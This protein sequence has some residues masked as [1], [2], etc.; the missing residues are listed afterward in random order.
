MLGRFKVRHKIWGM[1]ALFI[2][3]MTLL[4]A[5]G[6]YST[7]DV[8]L[9]EKKI[10]TRH[11]VETA[12]SLLTYFHLQ[13][14]EG[15][16]SLS[17]AQQ[18]AL[19]AIND[20]RYDSTEYFWVNDLTLPVPKMVMH[21]TL[22]ELNDNILDA[23]QFNCATSMQ[24]GSDGEIIKTDGKKNLF[25]AFNEVARKSGAGYVTYQWPKPLLQGGVTDERYP[26]LS[27]IK[28]FN[29]WGWV[30]GS[31][32]YI[33][34]VDQLLQELFLNDLSIILGIAASLIFLGGVL[35]SSIS[36]RLVH[37]ARA[38]NAM[39]QGKTPLAPL[40]VGKND[41][42][43][44]LISGFNQMQNALLAKEDSLRLSASVFENINEGIVITDPSDRILSINPSFTRLTGY[45][46]KDAIGQKSSLLRSGKHSSEFFR[47][48]WNELTEEG[49]WQGEISNKRKD[50]QIFIALLAINAVYDS[51]GTLSHYVGIFSDITE[52]KQ[53]QHKLEHMAHYDALTHLPNRLLLADRLKIALKNAQRNDDFLAVTFLDLDEFKPINDRLG[54]SAGD[55]LL[56]E[57]AERLLKSVRGADTV[58]RLGG[59]EFV[60]LLGGLKDAQE[61]HQA[62]ERILVTL[63]TPFIIQGEKVSISASIGATL[64]CDDGSNG[65][66]LLRHADQAMYEAKLAGRNCYR[67]FDADHDR[68]TR[69]HNQRLTE[70][71]NALANNE[72][73][74]YYQP[75]IDMRLGRVV[76][77]EALIRWQR[78]SHGIILP[79]D[80]LPCIQ[81]HPCEVA[82]GDWVIETALDQLEQWRG[83]GLSIPVSVNVSAAHLEED[84]FVSKLKAALE[85][86]PSVPRF[87]L[88][89]EILETT[90][91]S[92]FE[93]TSQLIEECIELGVG[94]AIDDFGTGYSSLSYVKK[95]PVN[96]LKIDKS[97]VIDMLN[98]PDDQA[99]IEGVV[100]FT[101]AFQREV[102]A[103]G[104]E[105]VEHG[106]MLLHLGCELAQGYGIARPMPAN[107]LPAWVKS[108]CPA[109]LWGGAQGYNQ[110]RYPLLRAEI[111]HSLWVERIKDMVNDDDIHYRRSPPLNPHHCA[112]GRWF[113]GPGRDAF[114]KQ[115]VYERMDTLHRQVHHLGE[116][117]IES[118]KSSHAD[119]PQQLLADLEESHIALMKELRQL[120][121]SVSE[122]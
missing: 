11:L 14:R 44:T 104:V 18:A 54:H 21:P 108:F 93:H 52:K 19:Q 71:K 111:D 58:A 84:D 22:P 119:K 26:K 3:G 43:G 15:K 7:R 95:L 46:E 49:Y 120:R 48:L 40:S 116:L 88:E 70:I 59:D 109:P 62:L 114:G 42:I 91:L 118:A 89:I 41:E 82:I 32:I 113:D 73:L 100:G 60:L 64:S 110:L 122:S 30:I 23:E 107:E 20:L 103:E 2:L 6:I 87:S 96:T 16:L 86:H 37:S 9:T 67:F 92:D 53:Q 50:G 25:V 51:E 80:F 17:A 24:W 39:T 45:S 1:L 38:L 115:P 61:A 29:E 98:Q 13:Q 47:Q 101:R 33:D 10:K 56:V 31:G 5:F 27:Y 72:F 121:K 94:F 36:R 79:D 102:I 66:V 35:A 85:R 83:M 55:S 75:K 74:L 68:I 63:A 77:A 65:E 99:I 112:F 97:F 57:V 76:G 81:N 78:P 117:I 69:E 90:A 34:D 106:A 28:I 105:S 12:H 4:S 8:L